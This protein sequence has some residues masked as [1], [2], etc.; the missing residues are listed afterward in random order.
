MHLQS[1]KHVKATLEGGLVIG[2]Q[3]S[4]LGLAQLHE[5]FSKLN[6]IV[7][8]TE[9]EHLVKPSELFRLKEVAQDHGL[10]SWLQGNAVLEDR[11]DKL[12]DNG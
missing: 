2:L 12:H 11:V 1:L 9:L 6:S 7:E 5:D 3:A 10:E 8:D 4:V